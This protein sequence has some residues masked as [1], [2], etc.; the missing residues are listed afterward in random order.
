MFERIEEL[1]LQP[2]ALVY[3]TDLDGSFPPIPPGY[4]VLWLVWGTSVEVPPFGE[5][6]HI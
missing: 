6:I 4:P 1:R 2:K 5:I 3:L